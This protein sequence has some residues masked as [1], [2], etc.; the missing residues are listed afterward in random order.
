[1]L[2]RG[3][4]TTVSLIILLLAC[5]PVAAKGA[6]PPLP[7]EVISASPY[8]ESFQSRMK[9]FRS[10]ALWSETAIARYPERYRMTY[11]GILID[12][13]Q[14]QIDRNQDGTA[15]LL[16]RVHRRKQ[17]IEEKSVR[18]SRREFEEFKGVAEASG[19]W[20]KY[21]EFWV[22]TDADEMCLDGMEALMERRD[23]RGCRFSHGNTSCTSPPGMGRLAEKMIVL[24]RLQTRTKWLPWQK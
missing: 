5:A 18:L 14:I 11:F 3:N 6:L 24:A 1:M 4:G 2:Q 22:S 20:T 12:S 8:P 15:R 13:L 19:L 23:N 10:E 17:V 16:V 7:Q 21:P 9:E